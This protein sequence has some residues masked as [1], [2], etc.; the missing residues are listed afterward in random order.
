[1]DTSALA[2]G[3]FAEPEVV[4][5]GEGAVGRSN[6]TLGSWGGGVCRESARNVF[7]GGKSIEVTPRGLY[8]GGRLDFAIPMD[9]TK[10]FSD[11][12]A[13]LQLVTRFKGEQTTQEAWAIGLTG[14][15]APAATGTST[16]GKPV[17]R[18]QVIL[19][20]DGGQATECQVE[21]NAFKVS[22]DG[23][24]NVSF[25]FAALKGKL[26]PPTYNLK[27]LAITGDGSET[28]YVGEIHVMR[29]NT[30]LQADAGEE[31]EVGR[32]YNVVF[33][34]SAQTGVSAV[35]YSWDFDDQ[36]GIQEEAVGDVVYHKYLK[37]GDFIAT[38]TVSDIF[39]LKKP[40]T[41]TVRVLVN[42]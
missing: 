12:D 14:Q 10:W 37:A 29:D 6:I 22:E 32:N 26:N 5:Y 38:L 4:I 25:P 33:H 28:F 3:L 17:K 35:K 23:W 1:M 18:V 42:E 34:A 39:G 8:Q 40:V 11:P 30:P 27:R 41:S 2:Q 31:K 24:M 21:L 20:F 7:S 13:Y 9:L 19:C 36:N 15:P 16:A